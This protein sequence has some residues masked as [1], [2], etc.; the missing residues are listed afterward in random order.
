MTTFPIQVGIAGQYASDQ[1]GTG[2]GSAAAIAVP[3]GVEVPAGALIRLRALQGPPGRQGLG[4]V[5]EAQALPLVAQPARMLPDANGQPQFAVLV[6]SPL[7]PADLDALLT[8]G[9]VD[10]FAG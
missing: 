2:S 6:Q 10:V 3:A 8:G 4:R 5:A 1:S 9:F 7:A